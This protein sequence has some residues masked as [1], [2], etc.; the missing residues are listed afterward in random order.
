MQR[1]YQDPINQIIYFLVF[2][3]NFSLQ[4][5]TFQTERS[6][7]DQDS[8]WGSSPFT[9][10]ASPHLWEYSD[11]LDASCVYRQFTDSRRLCHG[12]YEEQHHTTSDSHAH[13][14]AH[15]QTHCERGRCEAGRYFL[16][17][18]PSG[19]DTWWGTTQSLI[20]MSKSSLE[21]HEGYERSVPHCGEHEDLIC[22][23]Y[24]DRTIWPVK[25]LKASDWAC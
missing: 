3:S 22:L 1:V 2:L 20:P 24:T 12:L 16:G 4:Y 13:L 25:A 19:R 14:H 17:P 9:N 10:S 18:P 11:S 7:S 21:N 8:P 5:P 6:E 23:P 15:G